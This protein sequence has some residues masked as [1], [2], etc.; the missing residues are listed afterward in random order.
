MGGGGTI[1]GLVLLRV[2]GRSGEPRK[3]GVPMA[4]SVAPEKQKIPLVTLLLWLTVIRSSGIFH[5][6]DEFDT[7][8]E[9][10]SWIATLLAIVW[11][12][13]GTALAYAL[14]RTFP[15]RSLPEASEAYLGPVLGK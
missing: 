5:F 1:P 6:F 4:A 12:G 15:G 8:A 13:L 3:G 2:R 7:V 10:A 11:V 14:Y 9:N